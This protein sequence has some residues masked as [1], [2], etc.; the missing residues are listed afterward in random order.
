MS[1]SYDYITVGVGSARVSLA[2]YMRDTGNTA[3][4]TVGTWRTG[5]LGRERYSRCAN[6]ARTNIG[7]GT[8]NG[9][10]SAVIKVD[11]IELIFSILLTSTRQFEAAHE[12]VGVARSVWHLKDDKEMDVVNRQLREALY[13]DGLI[14]RLEWRS[15]D[16]GQNVDDHWRNGMDVQ[17]EL[18]KEAKSLGVDRVFRTENKRFHLFNI[19]FT[20]E[21][22]GFA[23]RNH[24]AGRDIAFGLSIERCVGSLNR[25]YD[26][27]IESEFTYI[28]MRAQQQVLAF[29]RMADKGELVTWKY[30]KSCLSPERQLSAFVDFENCLQEIR[31]GGAIRDDVF[32]FSVL[33][34]EVAGLLRFR[35]EFPIKRGALRSRF[36]KLKLKRD[37][38]RAEGRNFKTFATELFDEVESFL[39][40]N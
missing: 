8:K 20:R 34:T 21:L 33:L 2:K 35:N 32:P 6:R 22:Y 11:V 29:G 40:D 13:F 10:G 16:S 23:A 17:N 24:V 25:L 19:G 9:C 37:D 31:R 38:H 5:P 15:G 27:A 4:R 18:L 3:W 26:S 36:R 7:T 1:G 12:M 39:H 30:D 28:A 14:K